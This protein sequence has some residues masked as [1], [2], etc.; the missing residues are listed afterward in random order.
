M[1]FPFGNE[2][3]FSRCYGQVGKSYVACL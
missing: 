1:Q 3:R 2:D